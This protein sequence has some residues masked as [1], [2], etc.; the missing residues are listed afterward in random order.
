VTRQ[1]T[2]YSSIVGCFNK[3][4]EKIPS[5]I[6]VTTQKSLEKIPSGISV[7]TQKSLEKIPSGISVT[8]RKS[9]DKIPY[10][11]SVPTQETCYSSIE[12]GK[13]TIWCCNRFHVLSQIIQMGF[14]PDY[15]VLSQIFQMVFFLACML[16]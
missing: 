2:C 9:L 15:S 11:I 10:G 4:L 14:F 13:N 3:S 1:E 16:L 7:T 12:S 5:G 8:T 6:S